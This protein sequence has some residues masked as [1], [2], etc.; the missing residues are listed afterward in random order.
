MSARSRREPARPRAKRDSDVRRRILKASRRILSRDGLEGL[1]ISRIAAEADV[2]S[3]AIF[4]HFG[5]KEGLW[6]ALGVELLEE[7][8]TAAASDLQALPLGRER[9]RRAVESY[10]MIG[11]SEV[12]SASFEMMVPALRSPGLRESI[13]HLYDDGR[14]KLAD[15]LGANEHPERR[16]YLRLVG[17]VVLSFTDGL[18]MQALMDPEADF[19]PVISLFEEM[20]TGVLAPVLGLD[21]EE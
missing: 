16:E 19:A 10:F 21:S 4:Y 14:E 15:D 6:I 11:G 20:L 13:V 9:T 8:N 18:N 17:Q 12:Q 2:Y 1:T 3:S 5:G 7:A